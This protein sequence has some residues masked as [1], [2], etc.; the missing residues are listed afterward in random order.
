MTTNPLSKHNQEEL[1]HKDG[2]LKA[3]RYAFMPNKLSYCGPDKNRLLF[4]YIYH[5]QSDAGLKEIIS[6]FQ[7]LFP[8]LLFIARC[9]NIRDPF[10]ERIVKAYWIGN[11]YLDRVSPNAFYRFLEDDLQIKKKME[12]SEKLHVYNKLPRGAHPHHAFHVLNIFKR[13][14][15]LCE[16][17]TLDT[18]NRCK[19]SWGKVIK[20]NKNSLLV[21]TKSLI[22]NKGQLDWGNAENQKIITTIKGKSLIKDNI[23]I[24]D[25]VTFHWGGFCEKVNKSE[26]YYLDKYTQQAIT[27]ANAK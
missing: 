21:E 1:I 15:H 24:G 25:L 8:Y 9:N 16:P 11:A 4:E 20:N 17:H 7:T 13:T 3:A 18:M 26:I 12:I 14:G 6:E 10:D 2:L 5:H 22:F 27:L 23:N 19:I